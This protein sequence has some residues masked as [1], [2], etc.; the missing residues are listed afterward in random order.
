MNAT[1][2]KTITTA[3]P[4]GVIPAARTP[5]NISV[6][7]RATMNSSRRGGQ[8]A[9]AP[10]LPATPGAAATTPATAAAPS[11]GQPAAQPGTEPN[12]AGAAAPAPAA[13]PAVQTPADALA[14]AA[15]TGAPVS[16]PAASSDSN[17]ERSTLNVERSIGE[18]AAEPHLNGEAPDWL[19]PLLA[20]DN[21]VI[22]VAVKQMGKRIGEL[23][24]R[25]RTAEAALAAGAGEVPER[26]A[27]VLP[28]ESEPRPNVQTPEPAGTPPAARSTEYDQ[29]QAQ[30]DREWNVVQW[31]EKNR[32]GGSV[33]LKDGGSR[34]FTAE[35][36][37][38]QLVKSQRTIKDLD[39]AANRLE[40]QHRA[41]FTQTRDKSINEA[42]R[43]YPWMA[44]PQRATPEAKAAAA[45]IDANP[46][47]LQDPQWPLV[48]GRYVTGLMAEQK[49]TPA[50]PPV[51]APM[52]RPRANGAPAPVP[53]APPSQAPR[54]D[55]KQAELA[56]LNE[57]FRKTG[58]V[59]LKQ[60]IF[61]LERSMP[62][63]VAA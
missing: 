62:Q 39:N 25:L 18:P 53:G 31:C 57:E 17:V 10:S 50:I 37:A 45:Y 11:E 43:R 27:G 29:V 1:D 7:Q 33:S 55:P 22:P 42:S 56:R 6:A 61:A 63:G 38:D 59:K 49:T 52:A 5:Q 19:Q 9:P 44:D 20:G 4:A 8:A 34:E 35:E 40:E 28:A 3:A 51:A 47:V 24:Y 13:A 16:D 48:V 54:V 58:S 21:T 46:H 26:A 14:N 12:P 36:V 30:L 32:N 23:T 41:R 2:P 60:K 15:D